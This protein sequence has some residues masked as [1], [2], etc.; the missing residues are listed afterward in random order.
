MP[1]LESLLGFLNRLGAAPAH[2]V[3]R[4]TS[5]LGPPS[6]CSSGKAHP[7]DG[8]A[9]GCWHGKSYEELAESTWKDKYCLSAPC[10][11]LQTRALPVPAAVLLR[12]KVPAFSWNH[13]QSPHFTPPG[14]EGMKCLG[15]GRDSMM[16]GCFCSCS[17]SGGEHRS[18]VLGGGMGT[19]G[20]TE[21]TPKAVCQPLPS[22]LW[23]KD[24]ELVIDAM[25][26]PG[27]PEGHSRSQGAPVQAGAALGEAA[28]LVHP[29]NL[30]VCLGV[31]HGKFER[32][33][34]SVGVP[35]SEWV[36]EGDNILLL[37][38]S[39]HPI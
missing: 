38:S 2:S 9:A 7:A 4:Q 35:R 23:H 5:P 28:V 25:R 30:P 29:P 16:G 6:A 34:A 32:N 14:R 33:S 19:R 26:I 31:I 27:A 8:D 15:E 1:S 17:C 37:H 3:L 11:G 10:T 22:H 21:A 24:P 18:S 13:E 36:L 39:L 12:W 20:R